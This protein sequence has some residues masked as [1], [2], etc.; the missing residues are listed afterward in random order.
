VPTITYIGRRFQKRCVDPSHPNWIRGES[1][2][3][4]AAWLDR[5]MPRVDMAHYAIEGWEP[6]VPEAETVDAGNDG[7]P[8]EGWNRKDIATWLA[9]YDIK[10]K[11]YATK[12]TLLELVATVMSPDGVAETEEMVAES[13]ESEEEE[14]TESE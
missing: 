6:K 8:D 1:R 4:T 11:G 5:Y 13:A 2:E 3:V 10:P 9:G 7:V 12:S 14:S